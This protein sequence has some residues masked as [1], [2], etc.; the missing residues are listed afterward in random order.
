ML[1]AW[2]GL[3]SFNKA[4]SFPEARGYWAEQGRNKV[5]ECVGSTSLCVLPAEAAP[6][7]LTRSFPHFVFP[8]WLVITFSLSLC[9]DLVR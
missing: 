6:P 4:P 8:A 1:D 3:P 5:E 7:P 9:T 2:M